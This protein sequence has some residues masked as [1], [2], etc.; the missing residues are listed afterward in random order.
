MDM[1]EEMNVFLCIGG[2][3]H[4]PHSS[5]PAVVVKV[6]GRY[7]EGRASTSGRYRVSSTV[8]SCQYW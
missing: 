6:C 3:L 7:A 5:R 8:H 2:G 1:N 4:C